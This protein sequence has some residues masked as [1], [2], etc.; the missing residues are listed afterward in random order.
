VKLALL[1]GSQAVVKISMFFEH[2]KLNINCI[3]WQF[4]FA[5]PFW[6]QIYT[7]NSVH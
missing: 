4:S 1:A 6:Q 5:I 7:T 2:F 3:L